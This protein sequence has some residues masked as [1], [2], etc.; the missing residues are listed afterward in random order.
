MLTIDIIVSIDKQENRNP[1]RYKYD[2]LVAKKAE[3]ENDPNT[4]IDAIKAVGTI[5]L[6]MLNATV[7][8]GPIVSPKDTPIP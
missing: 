7:T 2:L 1:P 3:R 6:S 4:A 5:E 8:S